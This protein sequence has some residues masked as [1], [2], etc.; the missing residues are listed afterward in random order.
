VQFAVEPEIF[1]LFPDMRLAVVIAQGVN[2][3]EVAPQVTDDWRRAWV[4]AGERARPFGN[5][6]SHPR[7]Q[8]WRRRMRAAGASPKEFPSSI[9]AM[10]RRALKGG[11]PFSINPLVDFYNAV[12]LRH[13]VPA[14]GFDLDQLRA[15]LQLRRTRA[16]DTFLSMDG[17]DPLAVP[18][19]EVAYASGETILTRHFVWRQARAGLISA[20]TGS[21]FLVSEVLGEVGPAVAA[22]VFDELAE[23]LRAHFGVEPH[24]AVLHRDRPEI[25]WRQ[26]NR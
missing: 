24:G 26:T 5:A 25:G 15:P 22:A 17:D 19:G 4:E 12:S 23:G 21:V 3:G 16:G 8:P 11:S 6:Q 1:D 20:E 13:T 14:G 2:N 18:P 7:I 10:V 9:E